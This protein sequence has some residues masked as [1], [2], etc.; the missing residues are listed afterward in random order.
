MSD[1]MRKDKL[2]AQKLEPK[3]LFCKKRILALTLD[4]G[5]IVTKIICPILKSA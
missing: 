2:N 5:Y 1:A 3:K 4:R